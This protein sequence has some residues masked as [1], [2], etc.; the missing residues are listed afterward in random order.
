MKNEY[1][2]REKLYNK[3]REKRSF[4]NM[5]VTPKGLLKTAGIIAIA[6]NIAG[7]ATTGSHGGLFGSY[8]S[9]KSSEEVTENFRNY[10]IDANCKY[11]TAG[12]KEDSPDAILA[13][14][15]QYTLDSKFWHPV[16]PNMLEKLVGNMQDTASESDNIPYGAN[17]IGLD[18]LD[19]GDWYSTT[20][21]TT[22]KLKDGKRVVIYTPSAT[23]GGGGNDSSGSSGGGSGG[24][25]EGGSSG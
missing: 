20:N 22:V 4:L 5:E 13:L 18:G 9:L 23:I 11:F 1:S 21:T 6:A 14:D 16:N 24:G 12:A 19:I 25:G 10:E 8:G 2:L 15:N 7:C 17:V 3:V